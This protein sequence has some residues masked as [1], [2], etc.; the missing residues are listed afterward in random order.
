MSNLIENRLADLERRMTLINRSHDALKARCEDDAATIK[1]LQERSKSV[2][3]VPATE[4]IEE[5]EDAEEEENESTD[6]VP[7]QARLLESGRR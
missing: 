4:I 7:G 1:D 6:T 3:A 2:V 5:T